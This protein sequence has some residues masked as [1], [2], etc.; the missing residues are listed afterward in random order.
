MTFI[1]TSQQLAAMIPTNKNPAPWHKAMVDI[2]PKYNINTVERVA[3]FIAQCAH[4][5]ADFKSLEENLNYSAEALLRT[6]PRYFGHGKQ[7]AAEYARNPQ[8]IANYVYMDINRS[9]AGA[10]GNIHIGD[11]WRFRG[12]GI[13]QLT[14]RSNYAAFG[15]T[16]NLTAEQTA[17]YVA[18]PKG[19]IESAC[20]FWHTKNLNTYADRKDIVGMTK[21]INGG[22]IGLADRKA[23]WER[24][25]LILTRKIK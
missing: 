11:G 18:T 25:L 2:F 16:I 8:K 7:N 5:S 4:E 1:F 22:D 12:R 3:G 15:R 10:L 21:I 13:K 23:R 19:A 6:F 17:E 20:W 14:G 9:K 24:A